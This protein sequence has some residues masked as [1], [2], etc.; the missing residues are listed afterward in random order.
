MKNS[1][2]IDDLFERSRIAR[3]VEA[4]QTVMERRRAAAAPLPTRRR[5]LQAGAAAALV[6]GLPLLSSCGGGGD[7]STPEPGGV[8]QR[9]LFFNHSHLDHRGKSMSILMAG[10]TYPLRPIAEGAH[11]LARERAN[12]QFL[13]AVGDEHITHFVEDVPVPDGVVSFHQGITDLGNGQWQLDA[14]NMLLPETGSAEA[15]ERARLRLG[16]GAA[17]PLSAKRRHYGVRAAASPRDLFEEQALADTVSHAAT[18]VA[19]HKDMLS[20]DATGAATVLNSHVMQDPGVDDIDDAIS[21]LGSATAE[22]TPGVPNATGWATLRPLMD[23][24]GQPRRIAAPGDP[25][26]GRIVYSVVVNDSLAPLVASSLTSVLPGVQA[27]PSLGADVTARPPGSSL[28]GVLWVRKDGQ[29]NVDGKAA[30][31]RGSA[32][33][34]MAVKWIDNC[35]NHWL[36][37]DASVTPLG[38][39]TQQLSAS[40]T[41]TGLRYLSCWIELYDEAGGL[42]QVGTMPGWNDNTWISAPAVSYN[43]QEDAT[44][45]RFNIGAIASLGTVM[46]IPVYTDPAFY[47]SLG[48]QCKL[49]NKVHK[50]RLYAG[51]LG[52]G[53]NNYPDTIPIGVA[54]TMFVNYALTV[55]FGVLGAI[56]DLDMVYGLVAAGGSALLF[57]I[58]AGT[59]DSLNGNNIFTAQFWLD[60]CFNLVNL[61]IGMIASANDPLIKAFGRGIAELL[62]EATAQASIEKAIP[63]VG[64]VLNAES[65]AAGI[66]DFVLTTVTVA[67]SPFTYVTELVFTHDISVQINRDAGNDSTFPKA[68]NVMTVIAT[69]DDGKPWRQDIDLPVPAVS[70]LP[71]VV[72]AGV[73]FGGSVEIAVGFHQRALDGS[74]ADNILLGRGTTGKLPNDDV[75]PYEITIT[76]IAFPVGPSTRYRHIQRSY[77]GDDGR[78]EWVV[79]GA[80]TTP[81][82]TFSCGSAGE[83][84][85]WN[86]I[87]VRQ[88]ANEAAQMVAYAWR[89]QNLAGG[90]DLHQLAVMNADTPGAGYAI[91]TDPNATG[92]LNVAVSRNAAGTDSY[93][94]DASS[95]NPLVR[96]ITLDA[97]GGPQIDGPTSNRAYGMLNL[98]SDALLLHPAGFLVSVSGANDRFEILSPPAQP[99]TDS[100]ARTSK[101]AQVIGGT[102]N[103]PGLMRQVTAATITRDGTLLVVENGNNRIQAFDLGAN[104]VRYFSNAPLPYV[105]PLTEMP[106]EQ[107]WRHLDIQ[108]DFSGLLYVLSVNNNTGVYR[109][110]IYDNLSKL[111]QALSVTEGVLAARIGLDHWRDLYTL[112]YQPITIK[113]SGAQ[114][115]VTEPSVS[116][117]QPCALGTTC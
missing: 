38:D 95:S 108:A 87:G 81:P 86:G 47:G 17:L 110:S 117:W 78:H 62:G 15:Y 18:L 23:A 30:A 90:G 36:D 60:Q 28:R 111:Q 13:A 6:G 10:K 46:G 104:P 2:S 14:I 102:G 88:G 53:S 83:V 3:A 45:T 24:N 98:P 8:S 100:D 40:Y 75:T 48:I 20:L 109:L 79:E 29:P 74:V 80:P 66:A 94:V 82:A 12:N 68:A 42:L 41:N 9:T 85:Q 64:W 59:L 43:P 96:G 25:A 52:Y 97:S 27:D 50:V 33:A 5:F 73:P 7:S 57:A 34:S 76:E 19:M 71:P 49:S 69:F 107:G 72:F 103:R 58:A 106:P 37:L 70:T 115:P 63:V 22:A 16:A 92:A 116:M 4:M 84:C 56:P 105:L 1:R 114:P 61:V 39:G 101:I 32:A 89:G 55:L 26:D 112:N 113:T 35:Q 93:Y 11:V 44:K 51:G 67:Q 91:G 65:I 54:G 77:I 21:T 99:L 31:L